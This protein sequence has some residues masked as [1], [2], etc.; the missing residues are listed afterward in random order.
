MNLKKVVKQVR[1]SKKSG[2]NRLYSILDSVFKN[3][4]KDDDAEV[5]YQNETMSPEE[6]RA[7]LVDEAAND[8]TVLVSNELAT[9]EEVIKCV[10]ETI[11]SED[12]FAIAEEL[13]EK[14]N[15]PETLDNTLW[16]YIEHTNDGTP[17]ENILYTIGQSD[18]LSDEDCVIVA[19]II[20]SK[21]EQDA[22]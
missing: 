17:L 8:L 13:S 6:K 10:D 16:D 1:D 18:A 4:V 19:D 12:R 22:E 2:V 15:W 5:D 9:P 21:N 14:Y 11:S 3:K 20:I 7:T